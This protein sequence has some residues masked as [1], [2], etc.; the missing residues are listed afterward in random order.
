MDGAVVKPNRQTFCDVTWVRFLLSDNFAK[1]CFRVAD[2]LVRTPD[3]GPEG[4]C[5][6]LLVLDKVSC[7]SKLYKAWLCISI[8]IKTRIE[9]PRQLDKKWGSRD[10]LDNTEHI[11]DG[12]HLGVV[13]KVCRR[14]RESICRY[15][16]SQDIEQM[17]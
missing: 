15:Y 2:I 8:H 14:L 11:C 4:A 9:T 5:R 12:D 7:V 3:S 17:V 13:D 1:N 16:E 10:R 6:C